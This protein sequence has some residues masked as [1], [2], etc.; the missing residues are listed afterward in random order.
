MIALLAEVQVSSFT[1]F[2]LLNG[3]RRV[4]LQMKPDFYSTLQKK[5][6][7]LEISFYENFEKAYLYAQCVTSN[8]VSITLLKR[9]IGEW[10]KP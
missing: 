1:L 10:Q 7:T 4:V 2:D 8:A 3:K 5:C 9:P 6:F